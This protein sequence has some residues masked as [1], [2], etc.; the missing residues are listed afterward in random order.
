MK[1]VNVDINDEIIFKNIEDVDIGLT[2][3]ISSSLQLPT[4][5]FNNIILNFNFINKKLC[6]ELKMFASFKIGENSAIDVPLTNIQAKN[7]FCEYACYIPNEVFEKPC[8]FT[9]G[10]YGFSLNE[11]ETVKQRISLVPVKS[12]AIRG[13]YDADAKETVLPT[14]T[15]FEIYF[16]KVADMADVYAEKIL[17]NEHKRISDNNDIILQNNIND[18]AKTRRSGDDSLQSQISGLASGSPLVASSTAGMTDKTRV[19]VNTTDGNWYYHNGSS[20]VSGGLY[21]SSGLKDDDNLKIGRTDSIKHDVNMKYN[22]LFEVGNIAN[23]T[24]L[25]DDNPNWGNY[26]FRSKNIEFAEETVYIKMNSTLYNLKFF[27]YDETGTFLSTTTNTTI[28]A[29]TYFRVWVQQK[30]KGEAFNKDIHLTDAFENLNIFTDKRKKD[31]FLKSMNE[32]TLSNLVKTVFKNDLY[33]FTLGALI[34]GGINSTRKYAI[35]TDEIVYTDKELK[36]TTDF[37]KYMISVSYYDVNE[38]YTNGIGDS[39]TPVIIPA[40]S[41]F[42]ISLVCIDGSIDLTDVIEET[43]KELLIYNV[44]DYEFSP[45]VKINRDNLSE[46]LKKDLDNISIANVGGMNIFEKNNVNMEIPE[47]YIDGDMTNVT[48]DVEGYVK[49]KLVMSN[50]R[51]Q[52]YSTIKWQGNSSLA[53]PKKNFTIKL[54][55]DSK[56]KR[57]AKENIKWGNQNKYCLKANYIDH[58]HARNIVSARLWGQM[59]NSRYKKLNSLLE[60]SPNFGAIDGFPIKLYINNEY[61]GLYTWNI[62]KD[63]WMFNMNEDE[64]NHAVLCAEQNNPNDKQSTCEFR[65]LAQIN[66]YDW[67]LEFPDELNPD[68][69]ESFNALITCV[70]DSSDENFINNIEN[71][72]DLESAIDYYIFAYF[73]CN[74]DSLGKNLLMITY[75]G[76]TWIP[77][78]YDMDSSWGLYWNGS[79][80]VS[81]EYRCPEDYEEKYNLLWERIWTLFPQKIYDRYQELRETVL[82]QENLY[83]EFEKFM[84][85]IPSELYAQDGEIYKTIPQKDVDH[86][87][88][89]KTFI[90]ERSIYVDEQMEL[91]VSG[92]SE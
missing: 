61:Q 72:L 19:Y 57:K 8:I 76:I 58:S 70:K 36:A 60:S 65:A 73:S 85:A 34:G 28:E 88:Q 26:T 29:G 20:W 37:S 11:D 78:M 30:N 6:E 12:I 50:I 5:N 47:V 86:L 63:G 64:K 91:L 1:I 90:E 75:D 62:P 42:R 43:K 53:Y 80:F 67:S 24:G 89:I 81:A 82:S 7:K 41:Y 56:K 92:D 39:K 27:L 14:P 68:I 48:H 2:T 33:K 23:T 69:K 74:I 35:A 54:Y 83:Y 32:R 79:K 9:I 22:Y 51:L 17:V 15:E 55:N 87:T 84:N 4:G 45:N 66:G 52:R 59:V 31:D 13:S 40:D 3:G 71:Y 77:S 16:S 21:Q 44:S 25:N 49:I 10:L 18:E 38:I 46:N